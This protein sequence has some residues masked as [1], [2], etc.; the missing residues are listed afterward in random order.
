MPHRFV[1][2]L[3]AGALLSMGAC[4]DTP[5]RTSNP[6]GP[7]PQPVEEPPTPAP[8]PTA[9]PPTP[10]FVVE[11]DGTC[12][13]YPGTPPEDQG[14][15]RLEDIQLPGAGPVF[16]GTRCAP[17]DAAPEPRTDQ[18]NCGGVRACPPGIDEALAAWKAKQK[19]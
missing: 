9:N 4:D 10:R 3:A 14:F 15:A 19:P 1:V 2:P 12:H 17:H 6:P 5:T 7:M 13:A 16:V 11:P 8:P 18:V